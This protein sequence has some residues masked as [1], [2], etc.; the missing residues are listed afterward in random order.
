M[1]TEQPTRKKVF[2]LAA[3]ST[4]TN[5]FGL[6]HTVWVAQDG[7]AFEAHPSAY[8]SDP[9]L[10][11]EV[12][13][14]TISLPVNKEGKTILSHRWEMTEFLPKAPQSIINTVWK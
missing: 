11:E 2:K 5:S 12:G 6:K 14:R 1:T 7:E 4:N 13:K 3:C 9:V 8:G 10:S